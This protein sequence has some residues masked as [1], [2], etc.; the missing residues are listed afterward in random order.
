MQFPVVGSVFML[1]TPLNGGLPMRLVGKR[2]SRL[3][4]QIRHA[5]IRRPLSGGGF[6]EVGGSGIGPV[7]PTIKA[8]ITRAPAFLSDIPE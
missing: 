6:S 2:A 7:Q 1:E 3:S 4:S 8:T 5:D